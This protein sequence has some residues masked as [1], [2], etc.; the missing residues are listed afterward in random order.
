MAAS[1]SDTHYVPLGDSLTACGEPASGKGG[2]MFRS[3]IPANVTCSVCRS[4]AKLRGRPTKAAKSVAQA[5]R[6]LERAIAKHGSVGQHRARR[7]R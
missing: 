2:V 1:P 3:D 6:I 5:G 4:R 7:K